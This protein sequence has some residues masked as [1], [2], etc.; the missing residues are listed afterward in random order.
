MKGLTLE[1]SDHR[2]AVH[3]LAE[4]NQ[5]LRPYGSFVEV[6]DFTDAPAEIQGLL[7]KEDL[8]GSES[9]V[10]QSYFLLSREALLGVIKKAGRQPGVPG[11]GAL[12]TRDTTHGLSYPR[13]YVADPRVDYSRFDRFHFN[14]A[15]DGT[16]VDE[17]LQVLFGGG[18]RMQQQ[19][20]GHPDIELHM[21]CGEDGSGWLFTHPGSH[22]HIG[23]MSNARA[24]T[25]ILAQ[26][27]GPAEWEM[28][29][30]D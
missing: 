29:Y 20:A 21:D 16:S 28:R 22:P 6:I 4:V 12:S 18:F 17:I 2:P 13:L 8:T 10:L 11:G 1:F 3:Q 25:K 9:D 14:Q 23:S 7:K 30:I 26:V 15:A 5:A 19:L 24:G 27:I